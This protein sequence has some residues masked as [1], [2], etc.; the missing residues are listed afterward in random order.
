MLWIEPLPRYESSGKT[1]D[2]LDVSDLPG[3]SAAAA[4]DF[5]R[6][7]ACGLVGGFPLHRHQVEMLGKALAGESC[8]ITAG[9]GSGK[10]ESFLLPLFAY[11]AAESAGWAA[12]GTAPDHL[13]DWWRSDEWR[14]C[15]SPG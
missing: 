4:A 15:A 13:I 8:V 3:L 1:V 6:L 10:T 7:A 2:Q 14:D 11:L 9:T 12:P 5:K